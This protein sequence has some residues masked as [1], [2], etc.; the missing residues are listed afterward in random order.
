MWV[1]RS[2]RSYSS[3][4]LYGQYKNSVIPHTKIRGQQTSFGIVSIIVSLIHSRISRS[5][6]YFPENTMKRELFMID[7]SLLMKRNI[8]Y[9]NSGLF[10][11]ESEDLRQHS[12]RQSHSLLGYTSWSMGHSHSEHFSSLSDFLKG[13]MDHSLFCFKNFKR[14][15]SILLD[16]RRCKPSMRCIPRLIM[17]KKNSKG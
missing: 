16:M 4:F 5:P 13:S 17:G 10:S 6:G 1:W 7:L 14:H 3:H 8:A 12:V 11:I 15:W 2:C 9:E